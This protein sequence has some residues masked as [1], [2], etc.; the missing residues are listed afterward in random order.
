MKNENHLDH[1]S[2]SE[3]IGNVD[4]GEGSRIECPNMHSLFG[5]LIETG[6]QLKT[7]YDLADCMCFQSVSSA[8]KIGFNSDII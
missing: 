4:G 5:S 6:C 7:S 1:F 8:I 2:S 3:K